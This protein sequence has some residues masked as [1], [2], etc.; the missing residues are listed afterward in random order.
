MKITKVQLA[1]EEQLTILMIHWRIPIRNLRN[2]GPG[3]K[4]PQLA[5][6]RQIL[7][8]PCLPAERRNGTI[9][10]RRTGAADAGP[11][12]ITY[13]FTFTDATQ[14]ENPPFKNLLVTQ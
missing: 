12:P 13:S 3:N 9:L 11:D 4:A 1:S 2:K 10:R 7:P 6:P 14:E 8:E 5:R